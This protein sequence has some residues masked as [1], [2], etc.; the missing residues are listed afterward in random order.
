MPFI[1]DT[2]PSKAGIHH[3]ENTQMSDAELIFQ[4]FEHSIQYQEKKG[5]PVWRNYDRNA[6]IRDIEN[7]NQYKVVIDGTMA[8]VFSVAYNDKIIWRDRDKADAIYLHRI[9][10]NPVF[11]GQKLFGKIL[12]WSIEHC[13]Q[14]QLQFVRMDTWA[15]NANIGDYYK[16]FGFNFIENYTTPD[17]VELPVHNRNLALT[18]LEFKIDNSLFRS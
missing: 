6:I 12:D 13:K 17:S 1:S 16:S 5:Y 7:G 10:V 15:A 11:K 8:I 3:V 9:V 4:L 2:T 18:L 14:K